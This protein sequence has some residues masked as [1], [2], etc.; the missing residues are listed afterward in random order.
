MARFQTSN[1][2]TSR[3]NIYAMICCARRNI[4]QT[5]IICSALLSL[6]YFFISNQSLAGEH[7]QYRH[8]SRGYNNNDHPPPSQPRSHDRRHRSVL[9]SSSTKTTPLASGVAA[10]STASTNNTTPTSSTTAT[11]TANTNPSDSL[12]CKEFLRDFRQ[13]KISEIERIQG[14]EKPFVTRT[15]TPKPFY[16]SLHDP[17]LDPTRSSSYKKGF[18]YEKELSQRIIDIFDNITARQN[19]EEAIMLDV[20]GNLGWFSLLAAAHGASKVY[21]FEPNPSNLVRF[22][23]SL[24]LN[25][26]IHD[27]PSQ[28]IVFPIAKGVSD[29]IGKMKFYRVVE[30]NPGS[31]SFSETRLIRNSKEMKEAFLNENKTAIEERILGE[32]ELITLDAFAESMGWFETRP[33]I[34]FFKLDVEGFEPQIIYGGKKLFQYRLV[35][36]FSMEMKPVQTLQKDKREIIKIMLN[37]GYELYMHGAYLGPNKLVNK[38][39][40]HYKELLSDISSRVY[41]ENL[42]FRKNENW[43]VNK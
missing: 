31:Y 36:F 19:N 37:N 42:L 41:G 18:Y 5:F 21:M 26:W 24:Q 16:W 4:P 6:T 14:Y 40:T 15:N 11:A 17:Q 29:E 34:A 2:T 9:D 25:N 27:D 23:E 33:T 12:Y 28:D 10:V 13:G 39:Y 1:S 32:I 43:T 8:N 3:T 7:H 38:T 22:C 30:N 20:G 35:E